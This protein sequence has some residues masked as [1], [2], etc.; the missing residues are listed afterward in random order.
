MEI[1]RNQSTWK[2][3][4]SRLVQYI[5]NLKFLEESS[6]VPTNPHLQ[7][8]LG[9]T[10]PSWLRNS[11]MTRGLQQL[12]CSLLWMWCDHRLLKGPKMYYLRCFCCCLRVDLSE[13][14]FWALP[15]SGSLR[16]PDLL[17]AICIALLRV[18]TDAACSVPHLALA[19]GVNLLCEPVV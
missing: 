19:S 6:E 15:R 9:S 10:W 18:C 12:C 8:L 2:E 13:L 16:S 7:K 17:L 14:G 4:E 5:S 3:I 1:L 11:G